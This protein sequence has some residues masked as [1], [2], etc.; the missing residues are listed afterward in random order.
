MSSQ[1]SQKPEISLQ[2]TLHN[3]R[4]LL[5]TF[6]NALQTAT[7]APSRSPSSPNPLA[8]LSDA[9]SLLKAQ[10]TKL[11][12]LLLNKPS[13]PKEVTYILSTLSKSVLPALMSALE[14]L[15][16]ER[17]TQVLH[18]HVK[19]SLG[20]LWRELERLLESVSDD[21]VIRDEKVTLASTGV[22]WEQC[23]ILVR[24]GEMGVVGFVDTKV[25]GYGELLEDAIG[26]MED[27]DPDRSDSEQDSS[28]ET[29][30][31][32]GG[33]AVVRTPTTSED[34]RL[35]Q[36]MQ[37]LD[38]STQ[39]ILKVRILKHLRLIRLLY[40]ALRKR[41]VATFPDA[42]RRTAESTLPSV[43]QVEKLDMLLMH[44]RC[45]SEGA[46]EIAGAMYSND[47]EGAELQLQQ[48]VARARTCVEI[49]SRGWIGQED[50][51]SAWIAKWTDRLG[52]LEKV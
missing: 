45:F 7:T 19:T 8:L 39:T 38:L 21:G 34:E 11:S 25:K 30:D 46:D 10:T 17:Y 27:W 42:M 37:K 32:K 15:P 24:V 22:L 26:E 49:S 2:S 23:D 44:T 12:L 35:E 9:A 51:F 31:E 14:L 43:V 50:E 28:D 20:I 18:E 40:P 3:V 6:R 5:T 33:D 36:G 4:A 1:D 29:D 48:L 16:S 41:R 47:R 52:E 13:S